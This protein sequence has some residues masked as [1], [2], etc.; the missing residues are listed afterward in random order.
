MW[1]LVGVFELRSG[2]RPAVADRGQHGP[3]YPEV[4]SSS[5]SERDPETRAQSVE[6]CITIPCPGTLKSEPGRTTGPYPTV[7]PNANHEARSGHI[8]A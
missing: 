8:A 4:A 3:S 5:S 6:R 7:L 1:P 2:L